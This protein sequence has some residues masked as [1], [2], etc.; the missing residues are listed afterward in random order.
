MTG[1]SR[2]ALMDALSD[3][4]P[5]KAWWQGALPE[6]AGWNWP[7]KPTWA[8]LDERR[9]QRK[10]QLSPVL[11]AERIS[12]QYDRCGMSRPGLVEAISKGAHTVT[13]GHQLC[14]A[15]GPAFTFYKI[16]TA[17]AFAARLE[18]RW[19]TPVVPVFWLASEDHDFEEI[20]RLW[21]GMR[22]HQWDTPPSGGAVGRMSV[23]GLDRVLSEWCSAAG[24]SEESVSAPDGDWGSL[25]DAMR[26]WVHRMFGPDDVVVIDG[27]DAVLKLAFA[28]TMQREIEAGLV[29]HHVSLCDAALAEAGLKPQVHVRKCNLFHLTPGGRHRLE[30]RGGEWESQ[31][32]RTWDST[33]AMSQAVADQPADFSPNA[34]LRPVYQSYILPDV[35][36]VGGMAEV[37]YWLQLPGVFQH[38]GMI[39]PVL[40]PRDGAMVMPERWS[41][42]MDRCGLKDEHLGGSLQAWIDMLVE[43]GDV[44]D[45]ESW[46][47]AL[48]RNAE[49]ALEAFAAWDGSLEGSVKATLARM[50]GL[51][52]KLEGQSRKAFKRK[53]QDALGRLERLHR[54][55]QPDGALQERVAQFQ[56]LDA[57]WEV[58]RGDGA[59]L[60]DVL[61]RAF[62]EGHEPGDWRPLMHV[63]RQSRS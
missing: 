31:G 4:H 15:G 51:L 57:L 56:Y 17:M 50:E 12:H 11:L 63:L 9:N 32:G 58:G 48:R 1:I 29:H 35:A 23:D 47:Q 18:S 5:A 40:V 34:L 55:V 45:L 52:D 44:P 27:D 24:V 2:F 62:E 36:I 28:G 6:V 10:E 20:S 49:D 54:W 41:R 43:A 46:R 8:A 38:L 59:P 19:G 25:A 22:W 30:Q 21:D 37:A 61:A 7:D 60:K 3:R 39:Q 42:L 33:A 16:R 53:E 26:H 14:L 13:T